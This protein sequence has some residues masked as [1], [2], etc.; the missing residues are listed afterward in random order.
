MS[1]NIFNEGDIVTQRKLTPFGTIEIVREPLKI[2]EAPASTP[3]VVGYIPEAFDENSGTWAFF[4]ALLLRK[5]EVVRKQNDNFLLGERE[6]AILRGEL[7]ILKELVKTPE[8]LKGRESARKLTA[9][10]LAGE[11]Y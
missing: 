6:T 2:S 9:Q 7:M 8:T 5:I 1:E 4:K 11:E 10:P 3:T